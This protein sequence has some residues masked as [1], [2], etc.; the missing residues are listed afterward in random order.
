MSDAEREVH[1]F[2]YYLSRQQAL[3]LGNYILE[4]SGNAPRHRKRGWLDRLLEGEKG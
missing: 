1:L 3:Q 2:E 4:V